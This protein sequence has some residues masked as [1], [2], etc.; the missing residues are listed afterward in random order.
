MKIWRHS[1]DVI[2]RG[3]VHPAPVQVQLG[4][5]QVQLGP[6]QVLQVGPVQVEGVLRVVVEVQ[7][8]P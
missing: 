7:S 2:E 4:P 8:V 3:T 5:V 6:V 1:R